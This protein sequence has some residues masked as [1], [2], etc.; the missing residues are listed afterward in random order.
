MLSANSAILRQQDDNMENIVQGKT[1]E[2]DLA[3]DAEH[4]G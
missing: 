3:E 1:E 4:Y 2:Q